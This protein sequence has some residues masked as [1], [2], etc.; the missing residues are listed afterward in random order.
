MLKGIRDTFFAAIFLY[1][2][3]EILLS[4]QVKIQTHPVGRT[5]TSDGSAQ[6]IMVAWGKVVFSQACVCLKGGREGEGLGYHIHHW[7]MG[8]ASVHPTGMLLCFI[9]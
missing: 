7:K 3:L 2:T 9:V 1:V 8:L 4:N 6:F 5:L